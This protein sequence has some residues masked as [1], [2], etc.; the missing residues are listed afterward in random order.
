MEDVCQKEQA[1][2]VVAATLRQVAALPGQAERVLLA[3]GLAPEQARALAAQAAAVASATQAPEALVAQQLAVA[4]RAWVAQPELAARRR[5][6]RTVARGWAA[7]RMRRR[8]AL[9]CGPVR[10]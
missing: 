4:L 5:P 8:V 3:A 6:T 1:Q 9:R 10:A 7:L 2:Q